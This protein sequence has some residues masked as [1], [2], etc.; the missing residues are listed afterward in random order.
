MSHRTTTPMLKRILQDINSMSKNDYQ[1]NSWTPDGQRR[2]Y[3]LYLSPESA[4]IG[5]TCTASEMHAALKALHG[6]IQ[7]EKK[8]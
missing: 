2:F 8:E 7:C 5:L 6:Y 1:L 4:K 3:D